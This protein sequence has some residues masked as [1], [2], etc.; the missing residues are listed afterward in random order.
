VAL[1][2]VP[3]VGLARA[4]APA[5][6]PPEIEDAAVNSIDRLPPR[7]AIWPAPDARTARASSYEQ[8]PWVRSLNGTWKFHWSPDP[9]SR[10]AD[11]ARPSFDVGGWDSIVVPSTWERQGH[12]VPLFVNSIYPFKV[13]PPRVLGEPPGEYTTFSQRDPVGSYVRTFEVPEEWR[14]RR[15]VLHFAGVSSAFFVW[16]NGER[17]GYSEDSRLPAEFDVTAHV[18]PGPNRLA[19]EVY[20]YCDGSYLE[21]QDFWRLA[22]IFRDVFVRAVPAVSLWD[23]YAQPIFDPGSRRGSVRLHVTPA[24]AGR[25]AVDRYGVS[26][27]LLDPRGTTVAQKTVPMPPIAPGFGEEHT[28]ATVEAGVVEPWSDE[29]PAR[30]TAVVELRTGG[31]TIEAYALPV[32]FRRLERQGQGLG[33][34]GRELKV[35]GVN[36]HEFDPDQGYAVPPPRHLE[37]LRLLKQANMNFVRG[38]HYPNDPRWYALTSDLGLMVLDEANVESHGLSYLKRV[39]PADDPVWTAAG[40]ERMRRMVIRDRQFPSVVMWSLGNEAGWGTAFLAM[41]DAARAADPEGRLIQYADMNRAADLDSQTYPT[42]EWL[43]QHVAGK[44]TRKGER[45]EEMRVEQHGPYPSGRPFL[46]NEYAHSMGNSGGNLREYWDVIDA[47]PMLVGG[48]VWDWVDQALWGPA[49]NGRKG[50]VQAGDFGEKPT[51][52]H[53]A[54]DGLIAPDRTPHPHYQEIRKV[55]QPVAFHAQDAARG[56]IEMTNRHLVRHLS[57]YSLEYEVAHEG[58]IVDHGERAAPDVAPG[59]TRTVRLFE[60]AVEVPAQGET[61]LTVRLR[62]DRETAW[63]PAGHVVAWEQFAIASGGAAEALPAVASGP[64]LEIA[65]DGESLTV[66]ASGVRAR[67]DRNSGLLAALAAGGRDL[68]AGPMRFNFWRAPTDNDRGWKADEKMAAWRSAGDEARAERCTATKADDGTVAVESVIVIPSTGARAQVRHVVYGS[69]AVDVGVTMEL[70][71]APEL[72]RLGLQCE[73]PAELAAVEWYGRGPHEN[74]A[75]RQESAAVGLYRSTVA[76]WVTPY[77]RPQENGNRCGVRRIRFTAPDGR[78]LAVSAPRASPLS[79]SAWP[80]TLADLEAAGHDFE[81]PRRDRITLN[82]DH[83]QMG[84]GGDNSWGLE[85]HRAYRIPMG[86]THTWTFRL[87][88]ARPTP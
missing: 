73:L 31:R 38:C 27:A 29:V 33:F 17:V 21:D 15:I 77:V 47:H 46:M 4:S 68:L 63:A 1:V 78:G 72:P 66:S 11:F 25:A 5:E 74:Y 7:V 40:V 83:L 39:L 51:D 3:L 32:G 14:G 86:T 87:E 43:L 56:E 13:D 52:Y 60:R 42:P 28:L 36:R 22:G 70:P 9:A 53:K 88:P 12:G 75:D 18:K 45:G 61:F 26:V 49:V 82:L 84:V 24:N 54:C 10:P 41:R 50:F 8:S 35:R 71:A 62:L 57:E 19:V 2:F 55:Y 69:G 6:A 65:G 64:P 44:A 85:V 80:Y 59:E 48:F 34:N 30:Y 58:R 37:D 16:V 76:D 79:V 81:L 20:K 23:V 67:F